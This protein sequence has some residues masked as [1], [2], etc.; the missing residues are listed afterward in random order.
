MPVL[1]TEGRTVRCF[2]DGGAA[3]ILRLL[4]QPALIANVVDRGVSSLDDAR[5]H[6]GPPS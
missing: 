3:L 1:E 4:P 6:T 2:D 5:T